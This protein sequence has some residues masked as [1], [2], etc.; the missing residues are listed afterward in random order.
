MSECRFKVGQRV[1][2]VDDTGSD[3]DL[4]K[5]YVVH[6]IRYYPDFEVPELELD[7]SGYSWMESR[8][9]DFDTWASFQK[10]AS[11]EA[12]AQGDRTQIA[13]LQAKCKKL[14]MQNSTLITTLQEV[15]ASLSESSMIK[16]CLDAKANIQNTLWWLNK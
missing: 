8:F 1:V 3:L 10:K 14:E 7:G 12:Q 4:H 15:V 9:E 2:C 11:P 16:G 6:V 13:M 5:D